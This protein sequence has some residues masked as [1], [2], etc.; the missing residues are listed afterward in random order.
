MVV[1]FGRRSV[2]KMSLLRMVWCITLIEFLAFLICRCLKLFEMKPLYSMLRLFLFFFNNFCKH[3][4]TYLGVRETNLRFTLD[5]FTVLRPEQNFTFFVP[6]DEAW[7]KVP[8]YLKQRLMDGK[9]FD[10]L[11]FVYKRHMLQGQ[12]LTIN[13]L[14]ERSYVMMNN[15]RIS[16]RRRGRCKAAI[17][18]FF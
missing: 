7:A 15:Q 6:T 4:Q 9:H 5:P 10:A 3:R 11:Q 17:S 2:K 16:V 12:A 14:R 1:E 18:T 8:P 13:D